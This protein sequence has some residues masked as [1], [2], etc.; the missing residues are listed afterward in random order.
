MPA[1][2]TVPAVS[3]D[4]MDAL[5]GLGLPTDSGAMVR[6]LTHRYKGVGAKTAETLVEKFGAGLFAT[7]HTNPDAI[8]DAVPSH[9]GEQVLDA[10]R[11]DYARRTG[12]DDTR[13]GGR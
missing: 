4:A 9:R 12:A 6:Y 2:T 7:M 5:E 10:W 13:G 1:A 8:L 3:G 11:S